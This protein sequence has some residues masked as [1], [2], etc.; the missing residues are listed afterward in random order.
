TRLCEGQFCFVLRFVDGLLHFGASDGLSP[1]GLASFL[2]TLPRPAGEDTAAGR[3]IVHRA[4]SHIKDVR[5]D[6]AFG[7]LAVA[8][9]VAYRSLIAVP[10]LRGREPIGAI[11]VG[12]AEVGGFSDS[13]IDLLRM[14]AD[15]AVIALENTRLFKELEAKNAD[16]TEGLKQQTA[17]GEIL[18][19]ISSSPTEVQPV[20]DAIVRS[21]SLLCG[22]EHAIVTRYDGELLHLAAQHNPRP[23]AAEETEALFPRRPSRETSLS[24]RAF[25]DAR[26][27]HVPD[28]A[29]QDLEPS[30]REAYSRMR[31][32]ALLAVPMIHEDRPIGVVSVSRATP[33]P[34]SDRQIA[35]LRTFADQAVIAIENVRL[36]KELEARNS[37]LR[38]ALEQ[39]TATANILRAISSSPTDVQPVFD[40]IVQNA[41]ELCNARFGVLHRFDGEQLHVAASDVTPE[42]LEVL[43]RTYPMRPS[44]S[45]V[46]GRAILTRAVAEIPDVREDPEY[47]QDMAV[48]GAWR[49]LLGVP[50]LRPDGSPIGTIVVQRSEPGSFA[51]GHIEMLK[52]FAAQAVIAVENV[53]L[54][55]ELEARNREL[56]VTLEQ[57]T[58]TSELLKVIGGSTFAL[59]TVFETL[60][61]NAVR[62]C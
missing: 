26:M 47:R 40:T 16:L 54:F 19:V 42:V 39:Q 21:A 57:Q 23:R 17:T 35:L 22:G 49:S 34:F 24:A 2:Q 46:S 50:M 38:T 18:R 30:V 7:V 62:L 32:N 12:R 27:V 52:T 9:A 60:A 59:Q 10:M 1:E 15:Q 5:T 13:Q 45:Q 29:R 61:E 11:S 56:R 4:V 31:L 14:F 37:E 36:F 48:A 58:A 25:V 51:A 28:V 3:A 53:R 8:Q 43:Q 20:F 41:R 6:P 44:R 33:G 55:K